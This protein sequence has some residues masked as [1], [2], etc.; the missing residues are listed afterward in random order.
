MFEAWEVGTWH[1]SHAKSWRKKSEWCGELSA[2]EL[3]PGRGT[4]AMPGHPQS[5]HIHRV[6]QTRIGACPTVQ[7]YCVCYWVP[8][9][10]GR[11]EEVQIWDPRNCD[12]GGPE[13]PNNDAGSVSGGP[14]N[15]KKASPVTS[16]PPLAAAWSRPRRSK[17]I[18]R[19]CGV[20][21]RCQSRRRCCH[22]HWRRDP[23]SPCGHHWYP[24]PL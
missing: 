16:S 22:R 8:V 23:R 18:N 20:S 11:A 3:L 19:S 1:Y 6:G 15:R 21:L 13:D 24:S 10:A 14:K 12:R 5:I 9:C 17:E 2:L 4:M 7:V